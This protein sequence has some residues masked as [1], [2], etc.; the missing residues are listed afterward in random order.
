MNVRPDWI[1]A[2]APGQESKVKVGNK[3]KELGLNTVCREA[4]CPNQ[5]K[6]WGQGTATF[7]L[8][9][10]LCTRNCRFCD[11]KTGDPE[12]ALDETE[13]ER[14]KRAVEEFE[15]DYVVLTSVDRDDLADGGAE[16]FRRVVEKIK[17]LSEPPLVEGLI[18]D[19]SGDHESLELVAR[20]GLDVIGHNIETVERLSPKVRD[21]RAGY[22]LSLSVLERIN[23]VDANLVT[24]S[25]IMVGLGE[26]RGE[27]R[28]AMEDLRSVGVDIVTVG[29]YLRPTPDQLPVEEYWD[30]S[31]FEEVKRRGERMGFSSVVAG[32]FVRSSYRAKETYLQAECREAEL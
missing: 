32:P 20:S 23:Q 12:R 21:R 11:V 26:S 3:L 28:E 29:Q 30:S 25:S 4:N 19:F 14:L 17:K 10:S 27:V 22:R 13:P 18:P 8:M 5:G 16:H 1:Q 2:S 24:K 7:M 15:L 9:G 31:D 6:C